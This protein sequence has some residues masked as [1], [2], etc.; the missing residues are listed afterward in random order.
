MGKKVV[1]GHIGSGDAERLV[2]PEDIDKTYLLQWHLQLF[3]HLLTIPFYLR[4]DFEL[5]IY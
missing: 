4:K 3:H 5:L 1:T 2:A